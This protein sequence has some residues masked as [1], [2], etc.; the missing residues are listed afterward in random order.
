MWQLINSLD[1]LRLAATSQHRKKQK[2]FP[3][4]GIN[5]AKP[6]D[7]FQNFG[8]RIVCHKTK[9]KRSNGGHASPAG[10][11]LPSANLPM[12]VWA[13][14]RAWSSTW[15]RMTL[16]STSVGLTSY[17]T[18]SCDSHLDNKI[19]PFSCLNLSVN[20]TASREPICLS[21]GASLQN[22]FEKNKHLLGNV[23]DHGL[24]TICSNM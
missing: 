13:L 17:Q 6:T 11:S 8:A 4:F 3:N 15:A 7:F 12:A 14:G 5:T 24:K 23:S 2:F 19:F 22:H 20:K 16:V 21:I 1:Q 10:S 18:W 9:Q